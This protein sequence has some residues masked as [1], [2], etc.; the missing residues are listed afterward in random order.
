MRERGPR[1]RAEVERLRARVSELTREAEE[2]R[3]AEAM[4][5]ALVEVGRDLSETLDL[6]Q[7]ADRVVSVVLRLF[8]VRYAVLY[9]LD[10]LSG[11][12]V[13]VS[14]A[15][16]REP[17]NWVGTVL[18]PGT[19]VSGRAVTDGGPIWSADPL[20]DPRITVPEW[21][22]EQVGGDEGRVTAAVP[23]ISR[24]KSVGALAVRDVSGRE[25]SEADLRYLFAFA[26][27]AALAL[28]NAR[29]HEETARRQREAE[30]IARLVGEMTASL[31]V[32]D[33]LRHV[34][35]SARDLSGADS[36][37]LVLRD[38]RSGAMRLDYRYSAGVFSGGYEGLPIE[39]GVGAGGLVL[40]SGRP[41]RTEQYRTDPRIAQALGSASEGAGSVALLVVPIKSGGRIEGLL[42]V[43]NASPR[44]FT[45]R[46]EHILLRLA[47][48]AGV[49]VRN[50][51][52]FASEQ[53]ARA[54]AEAASRRFFDLVQGLDAVVWETEAPTDEEIAGTGSPRR[55]SFISQRVETLLGYP[56][57]RWTADPDFW[58]ATVHPEDRDRVLQACR[59]AL[60]AGR[61]GELEYRV[62]GADGLVLWVRDMVRV[63]TD[64]AGRV[65]RRSG[66]MVDVTE[67]R[68][69]GEA[70]RE[71]EERF[72]RVF[73]DAATG[74]ALVGLDG[75]WLQVNRALCRITGHTEDELRGG[76][77]QA[78]S[79]PADLEAELISRERL[80]AG[81]IPGYQMEKR[82][83]HKRG[84]VIWVRV[85]S[86]LVRDAEG[87]PAHTIA[88]IEDITAR[89]WA[90][91]RLATQVA[92]TQALTDG[93]EDR[94]MVTRVLRVIC[95][96]VGWAVGEVWR[97]DRR[98]SLLRW[99]GMWQESGLE[100]ADFER[101]S[102][103]FT[104]R[105]GEGLP[106]RAWQSGQPEWLM[107]TATSPRF[108]RRHLA[109]PLGL[110]AAFAFPVRSARELF[111]VMVFFSR[112]IYEPD[113]DLLI[114]MGD[115][116]AQIAQFVE[117]QRVDRALRR[118]QAELLQFQKMDAIGRLAG[119]VAHDFN[120]LLTVIMG[121]GDIVLASLDEG[122]P[123]RADVDAILE[124]ATR[125]AALT[126]Q[127][128]AFSRK[129][130]L[131]PKA[132][133][134]NL[135]VTH[136][137]A[138]L[139]RLIGEDIQLDCRLEPGCWPIK[140]DPS[141]LEQ[142]IVN[143]V[144]NARDAMPDGGRV[145]IETSNVIL[146]Q[147]FAQAHPEIRPG[148]HVLLAVE[149]TGTGM[150]EE[151]RNRLFEPFFTTKGQGKGT[152]LGLS[153]VFGIVTQHGGA[154][155]VDSAPGSGA[156]FRI[157]LPRTEEPPEVVTA[158]HQ[159]SGEP[160]GSETVLIVED[161]APVR[162]LTCDILGAAGYT[163][164]AADGGEEALRLCAEHPGT[165]HLLV[166][167]VVMPQLSGPRLARQL[168]A[169]RPSM[170]VL[171]MSGYAES[172]LL[173][174][175]LEDA[176]VA[177][178]PKPFSPD[179]FARKVREVLDAP[180]R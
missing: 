44:P 20:S 52:L 146:D 49:A 173:V 76:T 136:L 141:Q 72:R 8:G 99:A 26:D 120:N 40:Q 149:D 135:L 100:A 142:V 78:I 127:L 133:D 175:D 56:A 111:G 3:R 23:L 67:S 48:H 27:Q 4:A 105:E 37:W 138:M 116:G 60:A 101:E 11:A 75:R 151:T 10:P 150:D 158:P 39:P 179:A 107:D 170:R 92:V 68:R 147:S 53:A 21:V 14:A 81:E 80:L 128:L 12:L 153:M 131:Q 169:I 61:D 144:V 7:A 108:L 19:G 35:A 94:E 102:R 162:M 148:G 163:V 36:A 164:L 180:D 13:C 82:Y 174:R 140:A 156:T 15:G 177:F 172:A 161:D 29:L 121:R 165:I 43:G 113:P 97:L 154:I 96:G 30:V 50:A 38:P 54:E 139:R 25:F 98:S 129:Q 166:S 85:N 91:R 46:D 64:E 157:Y 95:E 24:G 168:L 112:D 17:N 176:S 104:F 143:L 134:V 73:E 66:V 178:I 93:D 42:Y 18:P 114:M 89:R 88:E 155:V 117:R 63:I 125:A 86:T 22:V 34:V 58:P 87:R 83:V 45:D 65:R 132:L 122:D 9:R 152:G 109:A 90:E 62:I 126:H 1:L 51:R 118:S 160:R 167:D 33:V 2:R 79:H 16:F 115:M 77:V 124:T 103:G 171:Y 47:G 31:D 6:S 106:G 41:F 57:E 159:T 70:L 119:G 84:H 145:T 110:H 137:S 123:R 28:E 69:L 5:S 130:V 55:F 32:D 59:A 74:M 71:S